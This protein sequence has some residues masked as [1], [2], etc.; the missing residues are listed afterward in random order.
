MK[1][2]LIGF[3][4][5]ILLVVT[6]VFSAS[7]NSFN[8]H[9]M[10]DEKITQTKESSSDKGNDVD[11]WPMY[12]HD[13]Q[14][15][16]Y[17]TASAPTN[18]NILWSKGSWQ[19]SWYTPQR[20]SP[21]IVNNTVYIGA[22]DPSYP[23]DENK[24]SDLKFKRYLPHTNCFW[25][26]NDRLS[27]LLW[28]EAYAFAYNA[29]TGAR[30]WQ[31]RLTDQFYIGGSP[32]VANERLYITTNDDFFSY[33][34]KLFC[35]D[36]NTGDILW[37]F[38]ILHRYTSPIVYN[39]KVFVLGIKLGQYPE[40]FANVYCLEAETGV[41][42]YNTTLGCGEANIAPA[43]YNNKLYISAFDRE[44]SYAYVCCINASN[45][46]FFW[47]KE[48][49]GTWFGSSPLIYNDSVIVSSTFF[50]DNPSG[51]L[52][53][54]DTETGKTNWYYYSEGLCNVVTPAAAYGN[55]Y[56]PL[57]N[58]TNY[59]NG[60]GE[61]HCLDAS[62]GGLIWN[63]YLGYGL[64]TH[65]AVADGKVYI[66]TEDWWGA[67]GFWDGYCHCIDAFTGDKIWNFWLLYGT[68]SSPAIAEGRLYNAI[69]GYFY[70]FDDTAPANNPPEITITG[71]SKGKVGRSYEYSIIAHDPEGED[72][73][74][75][76]Y[77]SFD[78]GGYYIIDNWPS[79]VPFT[80]NLD[81]E[82]PIDFFIKT[83]TQDESFGASGSETLYVNITE[84]SV[85][86]T[87]LFGS[88]KNVEQD[89][90]YSFITVNKVLSIRFL[91]PSI[92]LLSD[93]EIVITDDYLGYMG[94]KFI[95]G[96]FKADID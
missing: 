3:I 70:C 61:M 79:D 93:E 52:W 33:N 90:N 32:A 78:P 20:C 49:Q 14:I 77:F 2:E 86:T 82:F 43:L 27:E 16:G 30:K 75:F 4:I 55:I 13:L 71:P 87:Y 92:R 56:L 9:S 40:Y 15:T 66:F 69:P 73:N 11:W 31:T 23:L 64:D 60:Y 67:E 35:L 22:C 68:Q 51:C 45:G 53:S 83:R 10:A 57:T 72:L 26:S 1:K 41:E 59:T 54:L 25:R 76:I 5:C 85:K 94:D 95:F 21:V 24:D 39:G 17:T 19:Y 36:T 48:L 58:Y 65:P 8:K 28:Y 46:D 50:Q 81:F 96:R 63:T 62:T 38:S 74:I 44:T 18:N 29:E 42:I 88:I 89:G 7:G 47:S 37:N 84:I 34:G 91:P 80:F 6:A 12:H